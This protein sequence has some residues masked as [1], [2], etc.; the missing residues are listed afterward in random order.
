MQFL[1]E[2]KCTCY[3]QGDKMY[4]EWPALLNLPV[5]ENALNLAGIEEDG[6]K[7]RVRRNDGG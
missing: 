4:Y 6:A 5:C 3:I 7:E 1:E 2:Q